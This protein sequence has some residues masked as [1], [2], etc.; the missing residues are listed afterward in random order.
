MKKIILII[1]CIGLV[2]TSCKDKKSKNEKENESNEKKYEL[3]TQ[4][5]SMLS[6]I[7]T[8]SVIQAS[9]YKRNLEVIQDRL[10]NNTRESYFNYRTNSNGIKIIDTI[11]IK[12]AVSNK[13]FE[14]KSVTNLMK[15]NNRG[16]KAIAI[17]ISDSTTN[18][19][20]NKPKTHILEISIPIDQ[21][22]PHIINNDELVLSKGDKLN[23]IV[24]NDDIKSFSSYSSD[25]FI[26]LENYIL[27]MGGMIYG[28]NDFSAM[29]ERLKVLLKE[30]KESPFYE[31]YN[32]MVKIL[33]KPKEG[34]GGVIIEGP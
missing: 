8:I 30:Q 4:K 33:L 22:Q 2:L 17:H 12:I 27:K 26:E 24:L 21:I 1:L 10:S 3:K 32:E 20:C 34:G 16:L 23:V 7:D 5:L 19:S 29:T 11:K 31:E 6:K 28:C 18:K 14:F 9:K 15:I 13:N 25:V